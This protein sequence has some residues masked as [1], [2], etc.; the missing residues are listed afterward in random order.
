MQYSLADIEL[1]DELLTS[2]IN[3][4]Y[5]AASEICLKLKE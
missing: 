4:N 1:L 3:R 5:S 2:L